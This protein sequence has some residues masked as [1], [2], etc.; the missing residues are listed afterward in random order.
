MR[1]RRVDL[2]RREP[3]PAAY[4]AHLGAH[5]AIPV[6]VGPILLLEAIIAAAWRVFG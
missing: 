4:R 3:R 6:V 1:R 2:M 5:V